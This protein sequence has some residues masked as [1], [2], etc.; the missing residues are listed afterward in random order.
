MGELKSAYERAM[1][2][3]EKLGQLSPEELRERKKA[4]LAPIGRALA[5]RYLSHGH[6]RVL[7]H[8]LER[9]GDEERDVIANAAL[10]R[11]GEAIE[12]AD[13]NISQRAIDGVC[14]I[15]EKG[16]VGD[17]VEDI[18]GLLD[19]YAQAE[20]QRFSQH[21]EQIERQERELLHQLRI[22]GSAVG[23]INLEASEAWKRSSLEL[24]SRFNE[25]METLKAKLMDSF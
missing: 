6:T 4:E 14:I 1:E 2:K 18:Q 23:D 11:L 3:A 13:R 10:L 21:K 24:S 5:D 7:S 19:E 16:L 9:F 15:C 8:D 25:R 20:E 12:V 17:T 22:S